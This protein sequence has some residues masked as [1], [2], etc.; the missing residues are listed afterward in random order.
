[1]FDTVKSPFEPI[2]YVDKEDRPV[3]KY[4]THAK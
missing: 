3:L 4:H 2:E 1:M